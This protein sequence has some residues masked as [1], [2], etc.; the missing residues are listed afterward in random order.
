[1]KIA[2]SDSSSEKSAINETK[3]NVEIDEKKKDI[4]DFFKG[5]VSDDEDEEEESA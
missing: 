4:N 5:L 3:V 2:D 1:M